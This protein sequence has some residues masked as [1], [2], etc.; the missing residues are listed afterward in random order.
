MNNNLLLETKLHKKLDNYGDDFKR[1]VIEETQNQLNELSFGGIKNA[2]NV[3]GNKLRQS[4]VEPVVNLKDKM[5]GKLG[6]IKD[7]F[8]SSLSDVKR[9][10]YN[11]NI[12]EIENEIIDIL[13][14]S[15]NKIN[16][17]RMK[18]GQP[19][20]NKKSVLMGLVNKANK[21]MS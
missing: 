8:E 10:Y 17:K 16:Q 13:I 12:E 18:S 6:D 5:I 20:L 21:K 9:A 4:T 14:S 11:G 7:S 2:A 15:V 3:I 19:P 1:K